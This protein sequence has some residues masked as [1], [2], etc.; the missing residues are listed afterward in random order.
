M[1]VGQAL[2]MWPRLLTE[3]AKSCEAGLGQGKTGGKRV[4]SIA[5]FSIVSLRRIL[6][7][8]VAVSALGC[9][10]TERIRSRARADLRD[11]FYGRDGRHGRLI[12]SWK[13]ENKRQEVIRLRRAAFGLD[14]NWEYLDE[15]VEIE[16]L[17]HFDFV[18][19]YSVR[20]RRRHSDEFWSS[21][22]TYYARSSEDPVP[23]V[24]VVRALNRDS[25]SHK[26]VS[27]KTLWACDF[28]AVMEQYGAK[29]EKR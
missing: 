5:Y 8:T 28:D 22:T 6:V 2:E 23:L 13:D 7:C 14:D 9:S 19:L 25:S 20:F 1:L 26:L 12:S 18:V 15:D 10:D 29:C 17:K 3:T 21:E 27:E 4:R 24:E 16:E 11:Y